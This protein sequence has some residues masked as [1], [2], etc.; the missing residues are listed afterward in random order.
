MLLRPLL[1]VVIIVAVLRVGCGKCV[2]DIVG[3]GANVI[4]VDVV[5]FVVNG[6]TRLH[7]VLG[8]HYAMD[9]GIKCRTHGHFGT[10]IKK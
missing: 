2:G 1:Q 7:V 5:D 3:I 9:S 4:V 8:S 6:L 10:H